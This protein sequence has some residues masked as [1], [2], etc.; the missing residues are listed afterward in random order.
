MP[1]IDIPAV[2]G[3]LENNGL[4]I[5]DESSLLSCLE[6]SEQVVFGNQLYPTGI[7]KAAKVLLEIQSQHPLHDGN[8]RLGAVLLMAMLSEYR[9]E[10][11]MDNDQLER[12][13]L[14]VASGQ[15]RELSQIVKI[16]KDNVK[17]VAAGVSDLVANQVCGYWMSRAKTQC[18][19]KEGHGGHHR[20][21]KT[22]TKR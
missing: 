11:D 13:F 15:L 5:K 16:I 18:I 2:F 14:S 22:S 10:M 8:K 7:E 20:S 9:L 4:H 6:G 3:W 1:T 12:F 21:I 17:P 19:L